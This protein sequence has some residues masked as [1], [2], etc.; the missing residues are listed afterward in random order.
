MAMR[1]YAK[2]I[3]DRLI[4]ND[5]DTT[6][7]EVNLRC[8]ND[9]EI[10]SIADALEE[11]TMMERLTLNSGISRDERTPDPVEWST[12]AAERL[13]NAIL[14]HQKLWE[15]Q[16]K[17]FSSNMK[18]DIFARALRDKETPTGLV[19]EKCSMSTH[20]CVPP[21]ESLH[22]LL[23]ENLID[24]LSVLQADT[25]GL[26][27]ELAGNESLKKL[28]I[29]MERPIPFGT[30]QAVAALVHNNRNL[31]TL[32]LYSKHV[33][34]T[35]DFAQAMTQIAAA[36]EQS[37]LTELV[38]VNWIP[39]PNNVHTLQQMLQNSQTL[40]RFGMELSEQDEVATRQLHAL[41][42]PT[43]AM[44]KLEIFLTKSTSVRILA[45]AL[46]QNASISTLAI[47][48]STGT[49]IIDK[50]AANALGAL[51]STNEILSSLTISC[52]DSVDVMEM[53]EQ[54]PLIQSLHV[55]EFHLD[56]DFATVQD[57]NEF[58]AKLQENYSLHQVKL[59]SSPA[60]RRK[61]IPYARA[62]MPRINAILARNIELDRAGWTYL[63]RAEEPS[64]IWA[65]YMARMSNELD[66]LFH[67]LR[68]RPD[69]FCY[70]GRLAMCACE[71]K[72]RETV[73]STLLYVTKVFQ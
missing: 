3:H 11:N 58:V 30:L 38:L 43:C 61:D 7:I 41:M 47:Y 17:S 2:R 36:V 8:V 1:R 37:M 51:L 62:I 73:A 68:Q 19:F 26:V 12:H 54:L 10:V 53:A 46:Q 40:L 21:I 57:S 9:N 16:F 4:A 39:Q 63:Q 65:E 45:D 24:F 34:S 48:A 5:P 20:E 29:R 72:T 18:L 69:K 15:L 66:V 42:S 60:F 31:E 6:H 27:E 13:A 67:F 32:S 55:L 22:M 49:S 33:Q 52:N 56:Q 23:S 14:N 64:F 59:I 71:Y 44:E 35:D 25:A 70:N 50:N 28:L